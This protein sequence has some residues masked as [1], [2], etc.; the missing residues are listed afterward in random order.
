MKELIRSDVHRSQYFMLSI[1]ILFHIRTSLS[2]C[3][4]HTVIISQLVC[5]QDLSSEARHVS[6]CMRP[7]FA[8]KT[9]RVTYSSRHETCSSQ[10]GYSVS[11]TYLLQDC[12]T[13]SSRVA[14]SN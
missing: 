4:G 9:I 3:G 1:T 10:R 14:F 2:S 13:L 6:R 12:L 7:N 8:G 11:H 5:Q